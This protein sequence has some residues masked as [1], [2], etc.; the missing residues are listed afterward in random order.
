MRAMAAVVLFLVPFAGRAAADEPL[1]V[2][3]TVEREIAGGA[4]H[5]YAIRLDADEYLAGSVDAH[6]VEV[7]LSVLG[8][9]GSRLRAFEGQ[10]DDQ[11]PFA[12]VAE[13][14]GTYRLELTAAATGRYALAATQR[15]RLEQRLSAPT[16][17]KYVSPAI[18]AL[19]E[20]LARGDRATDAFWA[21]AARKGTP[22]VERAGPPEGY[23]LVTF[24]WRGNERTR[25]VV[26]FGSFT[27][28][29]PSEYRMTRQ[30]DSDVWALTVRLPRSAR[31]A[32]RLSPND[33]LVTEG[34]RADQRLA[35]LQADPLNPRR[36]ACAEG[37]GLHDCA[38]IA[39]LPD[40]PPQ[41]WIVRHPET[42]AGRVAAHTFAS[43]L[44]HNERRISVYTPPGYRADD[45][46]HPLLVLFDEDK[47]LDAVPTPVIL[48]NLIAARK[49][50]PLV[51]VLI[52]NPTAETR[53]R[54]LPPSPAFADFL[55]QE[56][57]PW[58]RAHYAV[59][60]DPRRSIVGG[61]SYGGIAAT[62]AGLRHPEVFGN[63]L[64]QSGSFQWAPDHNGGPDMDST[65]ETGWLARQFL[66]GPKLPLRFWM[67]AG[68]FELDAYGNGG[69]VLECSRHMRDVLLAKGYEVHYRQLASGHNSVAWR[70]TL[71]DGLIALMGAPAGD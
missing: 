19:R 43:A 66:Q 18:E 58:V 25:N 3:R 48:D 2:H 7:M 63:V 16:W 13:A 39:E 33:P 14:A 38:S 23:S 35:T 45:A 71:A 54:E 6:G 64:S 1:V 55:A 56:L 12:F 11:T 61:S 21:D 59:T 52:A 34:P 29:L 36:W 53:R 10:R 4:S 42:P 20:Q 41:P 70:G 15:L 8:P 68:A 30:G 57:L 62:Y 69:G 32:Y 28:R 22:L 46:P 37:A 50:P 9:D 27:T 26:V 24:L 5:A 40:A 65:T 17:E 47:Y 51:A 44:L 67:E 31:F 49:V 60:S